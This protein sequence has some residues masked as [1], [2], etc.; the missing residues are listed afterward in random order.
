MARGEAP[1]PGISVVR[2]VHLLES[3]FP[4]PRWETQREAAFERQRQGTSERQRP[5]PVITLKTICAE[6]KKF[7]YD[8]LPKVL[9]TMMR[10]SEQRCA[11]LEPQIAGLRTAM[12][13]F[14]FVGQWQEYKTYKAGNFVSMGGQLYHANADTNSRPGT[15]STWTLA[16]KSGRDGR[17]GKDGRDAAPSEPSQRTV[18]SHR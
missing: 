12:Q 15:D 4:P 11:A 3:D 5:P 17:D 14:R 1:L 2:H 18:R 7:A 6:I 9:G 8:V 10:E 16:V 13:E